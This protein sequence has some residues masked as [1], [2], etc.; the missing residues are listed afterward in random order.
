MFVGCIH[1]HDGDSWAGQKFH[2]LD[3]QMASRWR[4]DGRGER[5]ENKTLRFLGVYM[6]LMETVGL[7]EK[8]ISWMGSGWKRSRI[9]N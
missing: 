1:E 6:G 7:D 5:S 4:A 3:G 8:H 9:E 2:I